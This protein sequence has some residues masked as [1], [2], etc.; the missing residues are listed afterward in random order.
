MSREREGGRKSAY[1]INSD[2]MH[3]PLELLD[4]GAIALACHHEWFNQ[5]LCRVNDCVVR[6]G[7]LK[8]EF[9]WHKH[10]IEDEL[11]FVIEGRLTVDLEGRSFELG[12]SQG[13]MV[14]RGVMHRT[15]ALVRTVA[16]MVEGAT[17]KPT[18]D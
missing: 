9:H 6:V 5:A 17:V 15:R 16:L 13:V 4:L 18:G 3:G 2:I 7:V 1:V 14:P 11:F 8:G 12:P 10:D